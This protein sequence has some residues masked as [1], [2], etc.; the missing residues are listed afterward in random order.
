SPTG[1]PFGQYAVYRSAT[2]NFTPSPATLL[3]TIA[4]ASVTSYRDT[5]AAPSQPFTYAVVVNSAKSNEVTV[6]LPAD[7]Q[8]TKTLQPGPDTAQDTFMVYDS[9]SVN[10][11]NYGGDGWIY[12]GSG[13]T[14]IYRGLIRFSLNDLPATATVTNATLSLWQSYP[15]GNAV[16]LEAHQV[17]R[18]WTEGSGLND[19]PQCTG[20][21]AT[22]YDSTTGVSWNGPGADYVAS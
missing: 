5:T 14:A 9:N 13:S 18:S 11:A 22:W 21:G 2:P 16:T 10:C 4:D 7:G 3:T 12:V 6:T 8:A 19:N 1:N 17:T 20:D 15:T